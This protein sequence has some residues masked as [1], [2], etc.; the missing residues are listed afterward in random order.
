MDS[1]RLVP[2][3]ALLCVAAPLAGA[4]VVPPPPAVVEGRF[5]RDLLPF[6]RPGPNFAVV[7]DT[8][9]VASSLPSSFSIQSLEE[10]WWSRVGNQPWPEVDVVIYF[11][12]VENPF[13]G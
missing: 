12:T 4:D 1:G 10:T 2:A 6:S 11:T 13:F 5:T 9:S 7:V 8:Q 3:A